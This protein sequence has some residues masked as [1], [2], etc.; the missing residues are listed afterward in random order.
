MLSSLIQQNKIKDVSV[1]RRL[2]FAASFLPKTM[3]AYWESVTNFAVLHR[4]SRCDLTPEQVRV[5]V[6]NMS[7]IDKEALTTDSELTQE[8]L[9]IPLLSG[10]GS[11]GIVLVSDK[12]SC[13]LC[14]T[15]LNIRA[16]RSSHVTLYDDKLGTVQ[17]VHFTKY[18]RKRG[19]SYQQHYGFSTRGDSNQVTYDQDWHS[20]TYFM[21]SSETAFSLDFL[22]R[23]DSEI[24]L[25]QIS[26]YQRA[27]IY[28]DIH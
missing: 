15:K 1:I 11:H 18:C 25:G 12:E 4:P 27:D 24:L 3:P 10:A 19:C 16:D 8:I 9:D 2:G 7:L 28:N 14:K 13:T 5:V 26:Y 17:A 20:L 23:L 6:E 21:S 22:C